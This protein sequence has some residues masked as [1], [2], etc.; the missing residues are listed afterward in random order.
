MCSVLDSAAADRGDRDWA[1]KRG[2]RYGTIVCN[3]ERRRIIDLLAD[4]E[5]ARVPS[6]LAARPSITVIA[7]NCGVGH[8]FG[9]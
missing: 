7:R 3:L 5:A 6:C 9:R 2:N 4:R 1:C 8:P